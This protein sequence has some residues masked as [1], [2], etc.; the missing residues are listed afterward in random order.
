MAEK[1]KIEREKIKDLPEKEV[2]PEEL[3]KVAGGHPSD[4]FYPTRIKPAS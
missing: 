3:D 2:T 1:K 4:P